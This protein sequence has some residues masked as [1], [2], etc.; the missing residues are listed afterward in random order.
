MTV[1]SHHQVGRPAAGAVR[2]AKNRILRAHMTALARRVYGPD[3][4]GGYYRGL[5]VEILRARRRAGGR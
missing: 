2:P 1:G 4:P 3:L 5:A